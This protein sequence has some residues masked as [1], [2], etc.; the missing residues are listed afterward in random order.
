M[1]Q[2]HL[3]NDSRNKTSQT[4]FPNFQI[5]KNKNSNTP[6]AFQTT[7]QRPQLLVAGWPRDVQRPRQ[8]RAKT[9]TTQFH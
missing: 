9:T 3:I 8:R 2:T 4:T 5:Q 6:R 1:A 7:P